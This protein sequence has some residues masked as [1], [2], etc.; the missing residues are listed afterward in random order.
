MRTPG[1]SK[2]E[3]EQ[4]G[5]R[6]GPGLQSE[7]NAAM[8]RQAKTKT[9]SGMTRL[10][11]LWSAEQCLRAAGRVARCSLIPAVLGAATGCLDTAPTYTAPVQ[12][13]PIILGNFVDPPTVKVQTITLTTKP[14]LQTLK[15]PFRSIDAGEDLV[16]I[17]WRDYDPF[18]S[19][20]EINDNQ[21]LNARGGLP[22]DSRPLDEQ[23]RAVTFDIDASDSRLRGCHTVTMHLAHE[24][25]YP[26]D[27]K[28]GTFQPGKLPATNQFDIAQ[29]TWFFDVQ[30]PTDPAPKPIC[31]SSP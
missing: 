15:V 22:A 16:A 3:A 25:T 11:R 21:W 23:D 2:S 12:S 9:R 20:T 7:P 10:S 5:H 8:P 31:W 6:A 19:Q 4:G 30:D 1:G 26:V 29:V 28:T 13:P 24:S 27:P 14:F 17:F 18:K